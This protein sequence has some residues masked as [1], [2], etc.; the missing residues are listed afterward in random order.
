VV[1]LLAALCLA[2]WLAHVARS[3]N[4]LLLLTIASL[5]WF[6]FVRGGC[7]CAIG[8]TQNVALAA[9]DPNYA[10]PFA[11]VCFFTLPLAFTLF[12]GRTFCAA[13]CPLGAIQ[14]LVAV[15]SVRVPG[16]L[17]QALG[18]LAYIYLAWL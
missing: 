10:V 18:L 5:I 15:R 8:A 14:E 1:L 6:G 4:G 3:R 12:F 16:W 9:S 17:D 11:V 13:V 7:V 2:T